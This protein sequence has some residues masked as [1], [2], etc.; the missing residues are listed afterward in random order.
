MLSRLLHHRA[1][2]LL[3]HDRHGFLKPIDRAATKL[4]ASEGTFY[5]NAASVPFASWT[6]TIDRT[7]ARQHHEIGAPSWDYTVYTTYAL[8]GLPDQAAVRRQRMDVAKRANGWRITSLVDIDVQPEA[9]DLGPTATVRDGSIVVIGVGAPRSELRDIEQLA[10]DAVP[11]VDAVWPGDWA[12]GAV[13]EVPDDA[14][15]AQRLIGGRN[16]DEFAAVAAGE[17]A[18]DVSGRVRHWDRVVINPAAWQRME[19][20]G[21]RVVLAHEL[22]HVATGS[23]GKVPS[24]LAEGFADYVGWQ[25]TDV[26]P[27]YI[28]QDLA[29]RVQDGKAPDNL[30]GDGAFRGGHVDLAY[31]EAWLAA[32]YV[33]SRYGQDDLVALYRA[34][35]REQ[36]TS[37][38]DQDDALRS[39]LGVSLRKFEK[40]WRAYV[41]ETLAP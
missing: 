19:T 40:G 20:V 11:R 41:D 27:R 3:E 33:A 9:W 22:T 37:K 21:R 39:T 15:G 16:I 2:A 35:G 5:D 29:A 26:P 38:D 25:D 6:Y 17:S 7:S 31:E 18:T 36:G 32:R 14:E 12:R 28:A 34:M 10:A 8:A 4:R 23:V 1:D 30:P 13:V 24:W